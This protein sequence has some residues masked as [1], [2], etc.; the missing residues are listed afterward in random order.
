MVEFSIFRRSTSRWN[1]LSALRVT[2]GRPLSQGL[3]LLWKPRAGEK[4]LSRS[5]LN[6]PYLALRSPR[7]RRRGLTHSFTPPEPLRALKTP[8]R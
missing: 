8:P 7:T 2:D 5:P 3:L 1:L 6:T 4:R